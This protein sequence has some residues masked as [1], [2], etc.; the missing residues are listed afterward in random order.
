[1]HAP[2]QWMTIACTCDSKRLHVRASVHRQF[3]TSPN[4]ESFTTIKKYLKKIS[5]WRACF[6]LTFSTYIRNRYSRTWSKIL[7]RDKY[8]NQSRQKNWTYDPQNSSNT[9][10]L[11]KKIIHSREVSIPGP[12]QDVPYDLILW[13]VSEIICLLYE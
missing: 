6:L 8:C 5:L 13:Y 11:T 3:L 4:N 1:M 12:A 9:Q 2:T 7:N 10:H